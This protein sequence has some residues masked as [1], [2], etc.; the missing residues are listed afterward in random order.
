MHGPAADWAGDPGERSAGSANGASWPSGLPA[1]Q[2]P[3][4]HPAFRS[5]CRCKGL[6]DVEPSIPRWDRPGIRQLVCGVILS[7]LRLH[8]LRPHDH[9]L[10]ALSLAA[11]RAPPLRQVPCGRPRIAATSLGSPTRPPGVDDP[12]IARRTRY[13]MTSQPTACCRVPRCRTAFCSINGRDFA[14]WPTWWTM[15]SPPARPGKGI[16]QG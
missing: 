10:E 16:G 7:D 2:L 9:R 14:P 3:A 1:R 6:G 8:D 12:Q 11:S 15:L 4:F 5:E 13:T